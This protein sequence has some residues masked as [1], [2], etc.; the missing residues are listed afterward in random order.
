MLSTEMA[1]FRST[2]SKQMAHTTTLPA[3]GNKDLKLLQ[4][5]ITAEKFIASSFQRLADDWIKAAN[6]LKA[7]G[8]GEGDDL[9][10][11]L[12]KS[13]ELFA[14][15]SSAFSQLA[16]HETAIRVHMKAVRTRE[17]NLNEL[18]RRRKQVGAKAEA[19]EK[20][21]SKMNPQHKQLRM[22][23]E[24]LNQLREETRQLDSFL[25]TEEA[26]L[27]DYKRQTTRDWMTL[28][29]GGLSELAEKVMIAGNMGKQLIESIP[30]D[31]T[32]PGL[33]RVQYVA[34]TQTS[35]LLASAGQ[36]IGQVT[37][38]STS[39]DLAY[40]D[41]PALEAND[42]EGQAQHFAEPHTADNPVESAQPPD[43]PSD[44]PQS[45][46]RSRTVSSVTGK[47][48][49]RS[50][51]PQTHNRSLTLPDNFGRPTPVDEPP[52]PTIRSTNLAVPSHQSFR[53]P[54]MHRSQS[55][56]RP[57]SRLSET[58]SDSASALEA[59][60][61]TVN[62]TTLKNQASENAPS[63]E[64]DVRGSRVL[65]FDEEPYI[66]NAFL[67]PPSGTT[68]STFT[69]QQQPS[70]GSL[71]AER[72]HTQIL[73]EGEDTEA[74]DTVAA[75][76]SVKETD[77]TPFRPL[78]FLAQPSVKGVSS[79]ARLDGCPSSSSLPM[80]QETF[81]ADDPQKKDEEGLLE[82]SGSPK[83]H[84]FEPSPTLSLSFSGEDSKFE[85]PWMTSSFADM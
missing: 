3:L 80:G 29:F 53:P 58:G 15:V 34:Q 56:L 79:S 70:H 83:P 13:R 50:P 42:Q 27:G 33:A 81:S 24:Q 10:D 75:F 44:Q 14:L 85:F 23:Q 39:S 59:T 18:K 40:H 43:G 11:V 61:Q 5:L 60:D 74:A 49:D 7:W 30:L 6:S 31:R 20:K 73:E 32:E 76:E 45:R 4:D 8:A 9:S 17:E 22:Q 26:Q 64:S 12:D 57:A 38:K 48:L 67:S 2:F 41:E 1:G 65:G 54:S 35:K 78:S 63:G 16:L 51:S 62:S 25:L 66:T 37:F 77:A 46:S 55:S 69:H 21:L 84:R 52:S 82:E 68:P 47:D 72:L 36:R 71:S 28:K 19:A